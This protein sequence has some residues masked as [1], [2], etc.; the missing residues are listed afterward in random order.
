[1]MH[2]LFG[3]AVVPLWLII[4]RTALDGDYDVR[5]RAT[6]TPLVV[7]RWNGLERQN[8]ASKGIVQ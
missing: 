4:V 5:E 3:Y 2:A 6:S 1:M 8:G 7:A